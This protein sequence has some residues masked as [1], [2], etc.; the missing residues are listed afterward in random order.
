MEVLRWSWSFLPLVQRFLTAHSLLLASLLSRAS[1]VC[2]PCF[3]SSCL[4]SPSQALGGHLLPFNILLSF[5]AAQPFQGFLEWS[6]CLLHHH[7]SL[8][9]LSNPDLHLLLR[10]LLTPKLCFHLSAYYHRFNEFEQTPG[11]SEGQRSLACYIPRGLEES[12]TTEGMNYSNLF[13]IPFWISHRVCRTNISKTELNIFSPKL[14]PLLNWKVPLTPILQQTLGVG[15][16]IQSR[17][18]QVYRTLSPLPSFIFL[19]ST[20]PSPL[21]IKA[22]INHI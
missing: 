1:S 10:S 20:V 5:H 15:F 6:H 21:T 9:R 14:P 18:P 4:S 12:D 3:S 7:H 11:E 8:E 2:F 13:L 22:F 19:L 17:L 16:P